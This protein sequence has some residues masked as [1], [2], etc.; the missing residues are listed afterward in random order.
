LLLYARLKLNVSIKFVNTGILFGLE[1][2]TD[3]WNKFHFRPSELSLGEDPNGGPILVK[4]ISL[5]VCCVVAADGVCVWPTQI[6]YNRLI[7]FRH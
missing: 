2:L 5:N 6:V 4:F 1:F 7:A 3:I